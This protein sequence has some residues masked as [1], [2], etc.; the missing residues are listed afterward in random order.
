MYEFKGSY[1][2]MQFALRLSPD[3]HRELDSF[4]P[5]I[6]TNG[7]L[8][9][10]AIQAFST[11]FHETIHWWQ[12]VGSNIGLFMS[13]VYPVQAHINHRDLSFLLK[14]IGPQKSILKYDNILFNAGNRNSVF[15]ERINRVL[16]N[17]H[18]IYSCSQIVLNPK[19]AKNIVN[20][21]FFSSIGHSYTITWSQI[22]ATIADTVDGGFDIL[23]NIKNWEGNLQALRDE[24]EYGFYPGSP[25]KKPPFGAFEI[26]EGQARFSQIQYLYFATGGKVNWEDFR[27]S[28]MLSKIYIE[29]FSA[30]L[31]VTGV[32]WPDT[33]DSPI[34]ALF[35]LVCDISINP[36]DGFPFDLYHFPSFIYSIDPGIRFVL[37]CQ[38]IRDKHKNLLSAITEYSKNEY[39][40]ISSILCKDI[41]CKTPFESAEK[42]SQWSKHPGC[43][44]LLQE[45]K[46]FSFAPVNMPI[47]LFFARYLQFQQD[48]SSLPE[49]FCW[50]GYWVTKGLGNGIEAMKAEQLFDK[51]RAVFVDRPDGTICPRTFPDINEDVVQRTF[52]DFFNWN[53]T[54]ELSRQW[55]IESGPFNHDFFWLTKRYSYSEMVKW[56][57]KNFEAAYGVNPDNF[58]IL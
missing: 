25:I 14:N 17:W 26:F 2:P 6:K 39:I 38:F 3:V 5:G 56:A 51:H 27:L 44:T 10:S 33:P 1:N 58:N 24:K 54:Y 43:Q 32:D 9:Y 20:S 49:F 40:E 15:Q 28:G 34:V 23:P 13:L 16:N 31:E 22:I 30:F 8:T 21:P 41:I 7:D 37:L 55:I 52:E 35:L 42:V 47:R 45:N 57:N 12:H 36:T 4:S 11:Y 18:D 19:D 53:S 46:Q 48:K 29:T 50:P